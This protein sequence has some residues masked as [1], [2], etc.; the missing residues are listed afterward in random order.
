MLAAA[1][2]DLA[3][4]RV[5]HSLF[6]LTSSFL[7]IN[8]KKF[9]YPLDNNMTHRTP[10]VLSSKTVTTP[11][12]LYRLNRYELFDIMAFLDRGSLHSLTLVAFKFGAQLERWPDDACLI[13]KVHIAFRFDAA[14][15]GCCFC[16]RRKRPA[17]RGLCRFHFGSSTWQESAGYKPVRTRIGR[18]SESASFWTHNRSECPV[19]S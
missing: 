1:L 13:P 15:R 14:R 19:P 18:K 5:R 9:S 12:G 8:H 17:K 11:T 6:L 7:F 3:V 10:H 16:C 2:E 4:R